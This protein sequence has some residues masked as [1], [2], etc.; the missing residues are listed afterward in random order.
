MVVLYECTIVLKCFSI[1]VSSNGI[2]PNYIYSHNR[3]VT[4]VERASITLLAKLLD[5]TVSA[6]PGGRERYI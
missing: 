2:V 3:L 4:L 1:M 6:A 5:P